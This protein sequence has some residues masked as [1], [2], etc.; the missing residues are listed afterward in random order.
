MASKALTANSSVGEWLAHPEGGP[1]LREL[2]AQAGVDEQVLA[3][4]SKLPLQ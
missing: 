2:L 4:V 1:A 3:P